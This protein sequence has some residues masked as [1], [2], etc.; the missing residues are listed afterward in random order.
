VFAAVGR[1]VTM[2]KWP[3]TASF[4]DLGRKKASGP[5]RPLIP[6]V[7]GFNQYFAG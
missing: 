7:A 5:R 4:E 3:M 1:I 2:N 6:N